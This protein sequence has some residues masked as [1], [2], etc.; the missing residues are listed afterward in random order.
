[1]IV[2]TL[3]GEA[4]QLCCGMEETD[5]AIIQNKVASLRKDLQQLRNKLEAQQK[6][7]ESR[8]IDDMWKVVL[9]EITS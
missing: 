5:K 2:R 9:P 1:M 4:E 8:C 7:I 3:S 6:D